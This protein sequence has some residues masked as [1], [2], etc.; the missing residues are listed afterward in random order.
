M[1]EILIVIWTAGATLCVI[2]GLAW[3]LVIQ[4]EFKGR[5]RDLPV[6][7]CLTFAIAVAWPFVVL[8]L[9]FKKLE[10]RMAA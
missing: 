9:A 6:Y 8:M 7:V 10:E 2:V 1:S 5:L 3:S 4:D